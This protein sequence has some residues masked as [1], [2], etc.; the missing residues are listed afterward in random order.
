MSFV[1]DNVYYNCLLVFDSFYKHY[2]VSVTSL[3]FLKSLNYN[4]SYCGIL[5]SVASKFT[6][7]MHHINVNDE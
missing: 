4:T 3:V 7:S 1:V 2:R 6:R 5:L